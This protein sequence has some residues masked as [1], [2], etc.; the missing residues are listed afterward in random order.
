MYEYRARCVHVIDGDTIDVLMDLGFEISHKMRLRLAGVNT[1]ERGQPGYAEAA[2]AVSD[3][4][5]GREVIV[6]T[7]KDRQEKYGRYLGEVLAVGADRTVN[8]I[9]LD[10]QLAVPYAG[11]AR[12]L[13][14]ENT[15]TDTRWLP[16]CE[17]DLE[18]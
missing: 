12:W 15:P 8:Q 18:I 9:L 13:T 5:L 3:L 2:Q 11:G 16:L 4:I 14:G 6:R 17:N 10:N 1:P 7:H